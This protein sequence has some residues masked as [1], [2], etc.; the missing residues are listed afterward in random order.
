[1]FDIWFLPRSF[2]LRGH[3]FEGVRHYRCTARIALIESF[4]FFTY[5][6]IATRLVFCDAWAD[7][8]SVLMKMTNING[9]VFF[10]NTFVA[11][12]CKK[13]LEL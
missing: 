11:I 2:S 7:L 12:S 13:A 5:H 6:P 4:D 10:V 3:G 9:Q 8:L 1:M